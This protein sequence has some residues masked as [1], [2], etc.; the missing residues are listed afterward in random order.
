MS[1]PLAGRRIVVTRAADQAE[2][3]AARLRALGAEPVLMPLIEIVAPT[4][5]GAGLADAL[6]RLSSYNWLVVTSPN[7]AE[8]VREAVAGLA[9]RAAAAGE[10]RPHVAAVGTGTERALGVAADLVPGEQLAEALVAEFPAGTGSVLV[11]QAEGAGP[12]VAAGIA[13]KGWRV[14]VVAAY[15]TVPVVPSSAALLGVL[16]ADAVLFASGSAVRAWTQVFGTQTPAV[17]VA[18]GPATAEVAA[19]SGLK[20]DAVAAD[21]SLDGLVRALLT[22]LSVPD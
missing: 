21:H 14:D 9:G 5:E 4:D 2:P 15:R 18:I 1:G 6:A 17:A 11:A 3:L 13:A 8:R 20:I 10:R 19:N 7:G 12:A 22:Y 16:S